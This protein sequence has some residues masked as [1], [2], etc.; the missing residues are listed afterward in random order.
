[1]PLDIAIAFL[2]AGRIPRELAQ[3]MVAS[4]KQAMPHAK[5]VQL[6]DNNTKPIL[7]V[8]EVIRKYWD[9]QRLMPYRFL[10]MKEFPE[11]NALFLDYD[12]VVLKDFSHLFEDDF[13]VGLTYRDETDPSLRLSPLVQETM[14]Y[15]TGVMLS[16]LSGRGFWEEAYEI[17]LGMP[18]QSQG[19]WGDQ[20]AIKKLADRTTLKLKKYPCALFNYSPAHWEEDLS[21]KFVIHYKGKNRK[22]WMLDQWGHLLPKRK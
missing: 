22:V 7:G 20:L 1:M 2:Y 18:D 11:P 16:K 14:P 3:I 12:V 5:V 15:N 10:H 4:V 19:W 21:E 9:G 8:D 17:C 13:D 6:T